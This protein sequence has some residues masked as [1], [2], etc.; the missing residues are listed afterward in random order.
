MDSLE[1]L[2]VAAR[3]GIYLAVPCIEVA[4]VNFKTCGYGVIDSEVQCGDGVATCDRRGIGMRQD[5]VSMCGKGETKTVVYFTC[6]NLILNIY[7][8]NRINENA[9]HLCGVIAFISYPPCSEDGIL[10]CDIGVGDGQTISNQT[11]V[12]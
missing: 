6:T 2:G 1:V 7:A 12:R 10:H 5:S 9:L 3:L 8:N 11:V 4:S